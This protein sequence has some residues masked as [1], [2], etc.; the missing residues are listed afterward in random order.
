MSRGIQL[1]LMV[2]RSQIYLYSIALH[3]KGLSERKLQRQAKLD[4]MTSQSENIMMELREKNKIK[5]KETKQSTK[6]NSRT[7]S[8]T[9]LT[10]PNLPSMKKHNKRFFLRCAG[11]K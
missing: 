7:C 11:V 5:L 6:K 9:H 10:L 4:L 3:H 1:V 2:V 8:L